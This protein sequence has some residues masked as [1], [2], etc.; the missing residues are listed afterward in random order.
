M[1]LRRGP[2]INELLKDSLIHAV[3]RADNVEPQALRAVLTDA[4]NRF[5]ANRHEREPASASGPFVN[6]RIGH[7]PTSRG[8]NLQAR[9]RPQLQAGPCG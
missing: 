6:P 8:P 2:T 1:W 9:V 7:R 5:A 3:M 4:A